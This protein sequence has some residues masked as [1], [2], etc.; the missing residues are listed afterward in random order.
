MDL[1][2]ILVKWNWLTEPMPMVGFFTF[3]FYV[4][5]FFLYVL[6][7]PFTQTMFKFKCFFKW[8]L[9]GYEFTFSRKTLFLQKSC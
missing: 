9:I 1:V 8:R 7:I 4:L 5:L 2:T 3:I 6:A